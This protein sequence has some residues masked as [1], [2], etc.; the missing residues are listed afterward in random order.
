VKNYLDTVKNLCIYK[1]G[2]DREKAIVDAKS[3]F[4]KELQQSNLTV[5]QELDDTINRYITSSTLGYDRMRK[6]GDA[7][8]V[9]KAQEIQDKIKALCPWD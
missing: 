4:L 8:L 3:K 2:D 9:K 5:P 7:N 1:F 6:K